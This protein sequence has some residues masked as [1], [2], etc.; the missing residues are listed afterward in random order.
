MVFR[1]RTFHP[2]P[3]SQKK[4]YVPQFIFE[5]SKTKLGLFQEIQG[6]FPVFSL[7]FS[8]HEQFMNPDSFT[9]LGKQEG[10]N[11][12][13]PWLF[14]TL[15]R[16]HKT[17]STQT[18]SVWTPRCYEQK[19]RFVLPVVFGVI[20]VRRFDKKQGTRIPYTRI[21]RISKVNPSAL[22]RER[23]YHENGRLYL[24]RLQFSL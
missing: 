5:F 6:M 1:A 18:Y 20:N 3:P 22:C 23:F 9:I 2:S 4:P 15:A 13:H 12:T 7:C 24:V 8:V 10:R 16:S 21:L 11:P 17:S 14:V 19:L